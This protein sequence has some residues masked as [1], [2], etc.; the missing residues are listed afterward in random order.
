M[1]NHEDNNRMLT[2][3]TNGEKGAQT[4]DAVL[5]NSTGHHPTQRH[6]V[7]RLLMAQPVCHVAVE[8]RTHL[9]PPPSYRAGCDRATIGLTVTIVLDDLVCEGSPLFR[10]KCLPNAIQT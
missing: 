6:G 4:G 2:Y 1:V 9:P 8:A 7:S 5:W 3:C 10:D